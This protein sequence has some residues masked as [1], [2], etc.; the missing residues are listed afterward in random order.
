MLSQSKVEI[1]FWIFQISYEFSDLLAENKIIRPHS[2][3]IRPLFKIIRSHF[4]IIRP[5]FKIIRPLYKLY[6]YISG[7][8][9]HFRIYR[10]IYQYIDHIRGYIDHFCKDID[11]YKKG[12][13]LVLVSMFYMMVNNYIKRK[14]RTAITAVLSCA[15]RRPTLTGGN[16]QLPSALR[17]LTS[18]FGMGTGVTFSP[19]PPDYLILRFYSLKT[20]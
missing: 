12:A 3:I 13:Q 19:S 9:P 18:V 1:G 10:R 5:L 17:S 2:E 7:Y 11:Q 16:P 8:R 15:R 14:K 4:R 20:R 6:C